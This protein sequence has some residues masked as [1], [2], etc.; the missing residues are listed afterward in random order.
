MQH[1]KVTPMWCCSIRRRKSSV[2]KSLIVNKRFLVYIPTVILHLNFKW[3]KYYK[4]VTPKRVVTFWRMVTHIISFAFKSL[5]LIF[6]CRTGPSTAI[7]VFCL[8]VFFQHYKKYK[9]PTWQP[10]L[11]LL[12]TY[13][14]HNTKK[15]SFLV[16]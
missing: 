15:S 7:Y 1:A 5:N 14:L 8:K 11:A 6:T 10:S 13:S 9:T 4:N 16:Q 2:F 12:V 3:K